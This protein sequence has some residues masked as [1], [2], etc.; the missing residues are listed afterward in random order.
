M[1]GQS[2][3]FMGTSCHFWPDLGHQWRAG[4]LAIA[5]LSLNYLAQHEAFRPLL[6]HQ[7]DGTNSAL[8]VL[9]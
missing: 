2:D 9:L 1:P 5:V 8:C 4:F 7:I 3:S 6:S